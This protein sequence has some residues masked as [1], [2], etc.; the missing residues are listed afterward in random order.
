MFG[1]KQGVGDL[2]ILLYHGVTSTKSVGIENASGKHIARDKFIEHMR[3]VKANHNA[4]SIDEALNG[5]WPDFPIVITFDDG[6]ENNYTEAAPILD[7]LGIPATFYITSGMVDTDLMFWVD[8]LEDCINRTSIS[9]IHI[10]EGSFSLANKYN[11]LSQIK[12]ICK[13]ES[14]KRK[15]DIISQVIQQTNITPSIHA[16]DNYKKIKWHQVREMH[17]NGLFTIGGHSLCHDI[18]SRMDD[19]QL[20]ADINSS[21]DLLDYN[22]DCE[23]K[24]FSYP[25]GQEDHFDERAV[26]ILQDRG[27]VCS[28]TAIKGLNKAGAD[29]FYLKRVML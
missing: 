14:I 3:F 8:V 1:I 7:E 26:K 4:I 24:H 9:D 28:P 20:K 23:I 5:P 12:T 11:A 13:A 2:L 15:N 25:E 29:P 16:S 21:V 18:L 17:Q 22:L 19:A 10:D 6:F 27:I